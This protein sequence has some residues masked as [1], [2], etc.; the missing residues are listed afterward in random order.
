MTAESLLIRAE[1]LYQLDDKYWP[2]VV[3]GQACTEEHGAQ[4]MSLGLDLTGLAMSA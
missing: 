2:G 4:V 3:D 1:T